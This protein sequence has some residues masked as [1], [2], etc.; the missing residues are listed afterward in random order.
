MPTSQA[1]QGMDPRFRQA[2][3]Q[4]Q[5]GRLVEAEASVRSLLSDKPS[6]DGYRL[7]G[8]ICENQG[9]LGQAEQ[10]YRESLT[11]N[12]GLEF[13]RIRLGIV[14]C[15][16][17]KYTQCVDSLQPLQPGINA[18]P[19]ALFY[20][21]QALLE[22]GRTS[23]ALQIAAKMEQAA[24]ADPEAL[25]SV[26]RLLTERS[27]YR[28]SVP[29]LTRSVERLPQSAEAHY[30][31]ALAL[32]RTDRI[33]HVEP[34][35]DKALLLQPDFVPA[36]LLQA[37]N[38]LEAKKLA[39]A[40]LSLGRV[41]ELQPKEPK[42]VFLLSKVMIDGEEYSEAIRSLRELIDRF[43][44]DPDVHLLLL[45]A[46]RKDENYQKAFETSLDL[47]DRFPDYPLVLYNGGL[48]LE[49][50]GRFQE[51]ETH[52]RKLL[53][54]IQGDPDLMAGARLGLARVLAHQN[55]TVEAT[56]LFEE[57]IRL[58]QGGVPAL[59][60]LSEIYLKAG[61]FEKAEKLLRQVVAREPKRKQAY[62]QLAK[63]LRRLGKIEEAREQIRIFQRLN[64]AEKE[65]PKGTQ[66]QQVV[67]P[68]QGRS[69]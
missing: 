19:E 42:A 8:F 33:D 4:A 37:M 68:S 21:C 17:R 61:E 18:I 67:Q 49:I 34:L 52:L 47:L 13:S 28:E 65:T 50:M 54:M 16:G 36:L 58:N 9:K 15:K 40:K 64:K 20:L 41:L 35:L 66:A 24:R 63:V 30:L 5:A 6:P 25:L 38:R 32:S 23:Q 56:A 55:K 60:D 1:A 69:E 26:C 39:E 31:L 59:S 22:T 11:L 45:S 14:F 2:V 43:P 3:E 46:Y 44:E 27:L 29:L 10:A 51:A 48:D 62:I 53:P 12:P 7:L 57:A